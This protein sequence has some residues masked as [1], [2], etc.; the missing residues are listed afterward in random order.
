MT[1]MTTFS[2]E[3]LNF[4]KF[5]T[6]VLDEFPVALRQV[7][8]YMWDNQ[9]APTPGFQKWDDSPLVRNMFLSK[10]GGKT[11]YVPTSKSYMEWDCTGL[12]E[13]TLFAQSFAMPDG[14]GGFG[15]LSKLFVKPR[16][17]SSGTFHPSVKSPSGKQS[18]T[19]ALA[20]DQLR[21][22]RN[23]LCHQISTQKIVKATFDRY[24]LLAKDAFSALGQS[25]TKIDDIGKLGEND[26]PT[27][28]L[29]QLEQEL[30]R[31][32]FKQIED[33]LDRIESQVNDARSDVRDVKTGVT[34]V[35]TNVDDVRSDVKDVRTGVTGIKTKVE[36][37]VSDVKDVKTEVKDV[38]TKVEDVGSKVKDVKTRVADVK[39][40]VEDVGS[41]V[42]DMKTGVTGVKTKVEDVGSD[43]KD[44][45]TGVT[46]VKTK[47]EDIGSDVKKVKA[48][49]DDL[50][51]AMQ[52]GI[53]KGMV[54]PSVC[55][56]FVKHSCTCKLCVSDRLRLSTNKYCGF[57]F[58]HLSQTSE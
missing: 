54:T 21:L 4:F 30:R 42:K 47:V 38:K 43:V 11:K 6:V 44:V 23:S 53:S 7:F 45:K 1:K 34:D 46:D 14:R 58:R 9:V 31:E 24:I 13:A 48:N 8:V 5:S 52:A 22:L 15:T 32:K 25:S 2:S 10:E 35:R 19:F 50:K 56:R 29:Q 27:A 18:E 17:L 12:F 20:L 39:T 28:R 26:F 55:I 36:D 33:N 37:V 51:Q 3:Q 16:R 57:C 49:F 41:D 40:K